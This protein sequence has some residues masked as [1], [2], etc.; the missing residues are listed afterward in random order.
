MISIM[1]TVLLLAGLAMCSAQPDRRNT[2]Q[3]GW[4]DASFLNL[5]CLLFNTTAFY[6]WEEAN[7]YCQKV[8]QATLVEISNEQQLDFIQMEMSL[9]GGD[10][11]WT[12]W[13][14]AGREGAFAWMG[15][16][17]L[18]GDF[19][20]YQNEPSGGY[21]HNCLCLTRGLGYYGADCDCSYQTQ[22]VCQQI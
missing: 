10:Y 21:D 15:S 16:L 18:V 8:E 7:V 17:E 9:L 13:T 14:D 19:I 22:V 4:F 12:S 1:K 2:C 3:Q 20:W 11:W 5:G 6:T